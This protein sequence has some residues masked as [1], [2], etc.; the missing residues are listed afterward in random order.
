M[1]K[2]FLSVSPSAH[3]DEQCLYRLERLQIMYN[4]H[5]FICALLPKKGIVATKHQPS[6][7]CISKPHVDKAIQLILSNGM[8]T[9]VTYVSYS[10]KWLRNGYLFT[11]LSFLVLQLKGKDPTLYRLVET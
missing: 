11:T 3:I 9:E 1:S 7:G 6:Q 5:H 2:M 10:M 8:L 4:F